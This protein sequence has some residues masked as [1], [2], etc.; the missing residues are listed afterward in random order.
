MDKQ[1]KKENKHLKSVNVGRAAR[2]PNI[3]DQSLDIGSVETHSEG[4]QVENTLMNKQWRSLLWACLLF[5]VLCVA[6]WY[7][8]SPPYYANED[9]PL[10]FHDENLALVDLSTQYAE[11]LPGWEG[12]FSELKTLPYPIPMNE[13][14][15]GPTSTSGVHFLSTTEMERQYALNLSRLAPLLSGR[16]APFY[17]FISSEDLSD[18]QVTAL[19]VAAGGLR[20]EE[21]KEKPKDK[22][23]SENNSADKDEASRAN[24]PANTAK[25]TTDNES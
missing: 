19:L 16:I 25:D 5:L 13:R 17:G 22:E 10:N 6:A 8:F 23:K 1:A 7:C 24:D 15:T 11:A 9:N 2:Q 12:P 21:P 20:R 3:E 14:I 4:R 18:A